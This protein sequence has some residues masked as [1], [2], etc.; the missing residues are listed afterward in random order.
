M[1]DLFNAVVAGYQTD[2]S[3][4]RKIFK[5]VTPPRQLD[6]YGDPIIKKLITLEER[7]AKFSHVKKAPPKDLEKEVGDGTIQEEIQ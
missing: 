5:K 4:K 6:E 2:Q 3:T 7:R 1:I